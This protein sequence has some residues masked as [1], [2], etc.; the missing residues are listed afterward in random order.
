MPS[1]G[2]GILAL[3]VLW[4]LIGPLVSAR[5]ERR[6]EWF[7]LA[8]GVAAAT[9]SWSWSLPLLGEALLRPLK[10]CGALLAGSLFFSFFHERIGSGLRRLGARLGVRAAVGLGVL[11][12]GLLAPLIT[13]IVAALLLVEVLRALDLEEERRVDAAVLGAFAVGLGGSLSPVGGPVAA[14]VMARLADAPYPTGI[15][16]LLE[17]G[18]AWLLPAL[19]ACAALAG[20]LARSASAPAAPPPEDPLDLWTILVLAGRTFVFVSGL[21]LLGAGLAPA[22]D[23]LLIGLSAGVLY[24]FNA[25]AAVVDAATLASLEV[26]PSLTQDQLRHIVVALALAGGALVPGNAPNLVVCRKLGIPSRRWARTG[27]PAALLLMSS[28][29]LTLS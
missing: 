28:Y 22:A 11:L 19:V 2:D 16:Y 29:F 17:L 5:I 9:S 6:L 3:C 24:W 12:A 25:L 18:G 15:F 26:T 13:S 21:V 23:R 27:I 14:L 7:L 4:A 1:F 10:I 8:L 20:L